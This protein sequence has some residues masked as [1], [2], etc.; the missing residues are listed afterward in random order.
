MELKR[1]EIWSKRLAKEKI[2]SEAK[3]LKSLYDEL[4]MI[5]EIGRSFTQK[6]DSKKIIMR[7]QKELSKL[8]DTTFFSSDTI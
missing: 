1:S 8:M 6:L 4:Q 5:S 7:V 2:I 3:V